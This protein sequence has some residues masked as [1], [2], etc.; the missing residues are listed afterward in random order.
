MTPISLNGLK[1]EYDLM[2][3]RIDN[4]FNLRLD[5]P[6]SITNEMFNYKLK[7]LKEKQAEI[8]DKIQQYTQADE[9]YYITASTILNL[10]QRALEVFKNS[11]VL[12]KRQL[13]N[14]LL[15]NPALHGKNL[16]FTL[17]APFDRVLLTNRCVEM[18]RW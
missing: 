14:F 15:Q 18:L 9:N 5:D 3:K 8:T 16:V 12:E 2:Q 17:K 13:L 10:A 6:Q 7:E 1:Q 4:L 11:E